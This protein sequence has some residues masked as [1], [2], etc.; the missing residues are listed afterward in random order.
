MFELLAPVFGVAGALLAGIPIVLHML[1]RTPAEKMPFSAVRFL[2]P[3]LPKTT[4]RSTLEHWPLML[5]RILAVALIALAFARPFQRLSIARDAAA[6]SADRV[7]V[8]LDASASMR[9]D[10]IRDAVLTELRG[11]AADLNPDDTLSIAAYSNAPRTLVSAD[12]WRQTEPSGRA[13]LIER[14]VEDYEP[15]WLGTSTASA[16]L[17]AADDVA[18]DDGVAGPDGDRRVV[19]ITDFQQG[20]RLE[21]FRS[22]SWPDGVVLDLRVVKPTVSG[23]AG[24]SLV[25]D[26]RSGRIRVRVTN[27]DDAP[28]AKYG[29]QTFDA[30]GA[31]VGAAVNAD[32]APGQ[33]RTLTM[34]DV[35]AG[36]PMIA[37][38]E[39]TGD[40][41]PFDNVVDLPRE[42]PAVLRIA[43]AGATDANDPDSMLYYLQ[44]SLDGN[45]ARETEVVQLLA[46]DGL[47]TPVPD[48]VQLAFVT[49]TVPEGLTT[50]LS[51]LVERGG[52]VVVALASAD[53]MNAVK[54]LL[55]GSVTA[56]EADVKDYAMF[57]QIDFEHPLLTPFADAQFS[58]F[59]S[60]QF[61]HYR[62][63]AFDAPLSDAK[64]GP[65]VIAK[66]DT[67]D[68]AIVEFA[69][70]SGGR[71]LLVSTG[72]QRAD[73]QW[74]L[75][76]RFPS[77]IQRLV[78]I[79][80]PTQLAWKLFETGTRIDPQ[81]I[82]GGEDWTLLD[83]EGNKRTGSGRSVQS[84]PS[85]LTEQTSTVVLDQP[86]R[87][88][89]SST[90]D[91]EVTTTSLLV[92]VSATES[93][94]EPLPLG[95]LQAL[96]LPAEAAP[97]PATGAAVDE[98]VASQ[99]DAAEL[100]SRQKHWRL[101]LLAGL[102]CLALEGIASA[103]LERRQAA[104]VAA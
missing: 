56:V 71:V 8:L 52:T 93:R 70:S 53:M 60:I 14:V 47:A 26:Q 11:V 49:A 48:D 98:A 23:N 90:V 78:Q 51:Q 67:G 19:L 89:L 81:Q 77:M 5:L 57:G 25:E 74:A 68:P 32:V 7:A 46:A 102:G 58:D 16:A 35:E 45:E 6:G 91:G 41:H 28:V 10:G 80:C 103:W 15:D 9:R 75:S 62:K 101:M 99:L 2:T 43:H 100:E 27:S 44:R 88:T 36:Q 55:P 104:P 97:I 87:W 54:P 86:G 12:E 66:F 34:Q 39:L 4:K 92:T 22:G 95:Q 85:D 21:E 82:V 37:G 84:E 17:D 96:G 20:S 69:H 18:R 59:S 1:R 72:W 64:D 83:P 30:A 73:G 31:P 38:V 63:L 65:R 61:L 94:T 3:T 29:L 40:P 50:S 79:A 33:R 24:L 76:T 42:E 13:A